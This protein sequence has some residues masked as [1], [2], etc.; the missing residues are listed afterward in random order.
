MTDFESFL[1]TMV[2][3]DVFK[4]VGQFPVSKSVFDTKL[5]WGPIMWAYGF[6]REVWTT[7]TNPKES[8]NDLTTKPPEPLI[9]DWKLDPGWENKII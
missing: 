8:K 1:C 9:S 4:Q 7:Q 2:T 6:K 5:R 3:L